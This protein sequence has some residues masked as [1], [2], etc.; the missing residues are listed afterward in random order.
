MK[1]VLIINSVS[2]GAPPGTI[3]RIY[4]RRQS[5]PE[6]LFSLSSHALGSGHA[7]ELARSL[8]KL[9]VNIIIYGIEGEQFAAGSIL[10]R[11]VQEALT[12][13]LHLVTLNYSLFRMMY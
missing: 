7:V 8:V 9:P 11:E 3:H 13:V 1:N 4:A 2:S 6:E 12:E 10:S 5:M